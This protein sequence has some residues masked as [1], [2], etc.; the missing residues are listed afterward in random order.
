MLIAQEADDFFVNEFNELLAGGNTAE[1]VLPLGFFDRLVNK[2]T[3]DPQIYVGFE[4][5]DLY[6]VHRILNIF[7]GYMRL[8]GQLPDNSGNLVGYSL[9]HNVL[10]I[11]TK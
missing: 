7:F 9:E 5:R 11:Y 3:N 1:Y 2:T 6:L 4:E 10:E 8:A